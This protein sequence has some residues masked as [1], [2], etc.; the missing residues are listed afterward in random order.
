MI[1]G[2]LV[3]EGRY[4][5]SGRGTTQGQFEHS[6]VEH[7]DVENRGRLDVLGGTMNQNFEFAAWRND[8]TLNIENATL[9]MT[10]YQADF[11]NGG[12]VN[13]GPGGRFRFASS[14]SGV[15][16]SGTWTV[17]R[18]RGGHYRFGTPRRLA[19]ESALHLQYGHDPQRWDR[20]VP[21]RR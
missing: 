19:W 1:G 18:G 16:S 7:S 6:D 12:T 17:S 13:V 15:Y 5:K 8:G 11:R 9:T 10:G 3:N 14:E 21:R 4:L 2:R 20:R